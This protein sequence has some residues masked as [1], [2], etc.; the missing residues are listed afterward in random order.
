[1]FLWDTDCIFPAR[2]GG[3]GVGT[4]GCRAGKL[5]WAVIVRGALNIR[6]CSLAACN[7]GISPG[8]SWAL[9]L[10][11]ASLVEASSTRTTWVLSTFVHILAAVDGVSTIT[12]LAEALGWV[13][14]GAVS[15]DP[16]H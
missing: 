14:W 8:S 9:T 11:G 15:V 7:I 12:C 16:T 4:G 10:V 6:G 5:S 1:M 13:G 2:Q 3:A